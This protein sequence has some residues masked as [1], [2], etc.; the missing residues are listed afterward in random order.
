[1]SDNTESVNPPVQEVSEH[2]DQQKPQHYKPDN[3]LK[4]IEEED[5]KAE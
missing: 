1:M 3:E 4:S 2:L 5:E